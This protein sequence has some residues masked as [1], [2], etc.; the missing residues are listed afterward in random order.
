MKSAFEKEYL[1]DYLSPASTLVMEALKKYGSISLKVPPSSITLNNILN[2]L[3]DFRELVYLMKWDVTTAIL[4]DEHTFKVENECGYRAGPP[5]DTDQSTG[6][7]A[8]P[9]EFAKIPNTVIFPIDGISVKRAPDLNLTQLQREQPLSPLHRDNNNNIVS[10]Q[11]AM[12]PNVVQHAQQSQ[13]QPLDLTVSQREHPLDSLLARDSTVSQQQQQQQQQQHWQQQQQITAPTSVTQQVQQSQTQQPLQPLFHIPAT[14]TK[15]DIQ[16]PIQIMAE[17]EKTQ[18]GRSDIIL[19]SE[20]RSL[21]PSPPIPLQTSLPTPLTPLTPVPRYLQDTSR[22]PPSLLKS[23][24]TLPTSLIPLVPVPTDAQPV[25]IKEAQPVS[26]KEAQ[27]ENLYINY[28]SY[29]N[30]IHNSCDTTVSSSDDVVMRPLGAS[31]AKRTRTSNISKQRKSGEMV[32]LYNVLLSTITAIASNNSYY[33]F[34]VGPD[35]IDQITYPTY[36]EG[37]G[38]W[39]IG[40]R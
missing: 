19:E 31:L 11:I 10:H 32:S 37:G 18:S 33:F 35:I 3:Q 1:K 36:S 28:N 21:Q 2:F 5:I 12:P 40:S 27:S 17:V 13:A 8:P 30:N 20:G 34:Q 26:T 25:S 16:R 22:I 9:R 4:F 38:E 23:C 15:V 7:L 6:Y 39:V 24:K 14:L 29:P